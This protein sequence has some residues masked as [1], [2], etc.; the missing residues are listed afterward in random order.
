MINGYVSN[1]TLANNQC[2]LCRGSISYMTKSVYI[3]FETSF[4]AFP[5]RLISIVQ[6]TY[7]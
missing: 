7:N 2:L 5:K 4:P 6:E 1:N 3:L